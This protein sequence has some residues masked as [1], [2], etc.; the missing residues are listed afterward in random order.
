[1][2]DNVLCLVKGFCFF[3]I[4]NRKI[5]ELVFYRSFRF[6]CSG[7]DVVLR[8]RFFR[9]LVRFFDGNELRSVWLFEVNLWSFNFFFLLSVFLVLSMRLMVFFLLLYDNSLLLM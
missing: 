8:L 6:F 3:D 5:F 4:L 1:M 9:F 7:S 2:I